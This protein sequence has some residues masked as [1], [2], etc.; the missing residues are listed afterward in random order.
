M[1]YSTCSNSARSSFY[2]A[3]EGR[4]RLAYILVK[5]GESS[6]NTSSTI[7]RSGLRG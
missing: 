6:A 4:P 1:V 7:F 2:G 5:R 3:I